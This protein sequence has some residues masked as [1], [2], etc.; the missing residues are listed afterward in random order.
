MPLFVLS[1]NYLW[2]QEIKGQFH[3]LQVLCWEDYGGGGSGRRRRRERE[4]EA[5]RDTQRTREERKG[6]K[7]WR[8]EKDGGK[9]EARGKEA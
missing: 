9:M 8:G 6:R 1:E 4:T 7:T 5:G 3:Q 2:K